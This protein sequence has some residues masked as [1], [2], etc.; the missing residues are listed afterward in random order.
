M[1]RFAPLWIV[2]CLIVLPSSTAAQISS[3]V[4]LLCNW[5]D[6]TIP[7]VGTQRFTD[8]WG[9]VWKGK[10]YGVIG[11]MTGTHIID[12]EECKQ[13]AYYPGRSINTVHREFKTYGHYLYGVADEGVATMQVFD[14]S[15]LPDS[16]H[17]AWESNPTDFSR[18]H[19][20]SIDTARGRL[21][22]ASVSPLGGAHDNIR[23]YSLANPELP[24]M[25]MANNDFGNSH[26]I[27]ARN[28]TVWASNGYEGYRVFD[29]SQLPAVKV[30]GG[31]LNY[32]Y[33]GFNHSSWMGY[34]YI[35]VMADEDFG[36]PVKVIDA[37][38]PAVIE[39]LSTFGP[40]GGGMDANCMPHNPYLLGHFAL[41]SYYQDGLQIFDLSDPYH[42]VQAGYYDTYL[43]GSAHTFAGAWGCYPYLPSRRILVGDMQ[44]G[45]YVLDADEA[46]KIDKD[47]RFSIFP[48]PADDK[49]YMQL[50][51][52]S[53]GHL[54]TVIY[55]IN[56]AVV[57]RKELEVTG[58]SNPPLVL[59]LPPS[60]RPGMYALRAFIGN[61]SYTA[62]FIKR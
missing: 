51:Y 21:Y 45:L 23:A 13:K 54:T 60:C 50:P 26:D 18:C 37:R 59:S 19:N 29:M 62:R 46:M 3:K 53:S 40:N 5:Q 28:D 58:D 49:L 61:Q 41:V 39:V 20:I 12:L 27:Y 14:Y 16:L 1:R 55:S 25:I 35:G 2:Y 43:W 56:G 8:V 4:K 30:I 48:N 11:S 42:P 24:V 9:L 6:T 22:C 57:A 44:T 47:A 38:N 34:D 10:E 17:L 32:P 52:G 36:K 31:L 15:Y 7:G 33:K